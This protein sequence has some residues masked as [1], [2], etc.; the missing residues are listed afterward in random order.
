MYSTDHAPWSQAPRMACRRC[1]SSTIPE[2]VP[3]QLLVRPKDLEAIA[4][5]ALKLV[6]GFFFQTKEGKNNKCTIEFIVF[7]VTD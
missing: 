5:V 4:A 3:C 2:G 7:S 1:P 6:T